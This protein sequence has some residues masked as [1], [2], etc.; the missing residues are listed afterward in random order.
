MHNYTDLTYSDAI[1][2]IMLNNGYFVPLKLLYE[3]IWN[4]KDKSKII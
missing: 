3:Q 2:Q 4:Y 1:E